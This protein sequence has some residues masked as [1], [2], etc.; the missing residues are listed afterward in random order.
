[1]KEYVLTKTVF[2]IKFEAPG[3]GNTIN[4]NSDQLVTNRRTV[5]IA[6]NDMCRLLL[7]VGLHCQS[8]S[9]EHEK[10][11]FYICTEIVM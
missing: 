5:F 11:M 6:E 2:I 3:V 9:E 8:D 10:F 7:S 4:G 1:M